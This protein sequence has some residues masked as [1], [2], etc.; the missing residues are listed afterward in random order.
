MGHP[1]ITIIFLN[2]THMSVRQEP[3]IF[4]TSLKLPES[5]YK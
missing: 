1:L 2:E 3:F 5:E 4:D